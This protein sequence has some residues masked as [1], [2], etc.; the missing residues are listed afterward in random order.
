MTTDL[1]V[2]VG[3][4][5]YGTM[6]KA[7][8]YGYTA[9]PVIRSLPVLPR[10]QVISGRDKGAV[11]AACTRLGLNRW[12]ADWRE[13]VESDDVDI[14]D[15]CTPP[16][17]H[18]EII[19]AAAASGKAIICEKPLEVSFATWRMGCGSNLSAMRWSAPRRRAHGCV[20]RASVRE[21]ESSLAANEGARW[22]A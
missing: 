16:G 20:P 19:Q 14:V 1:D 5:G 4:V 22:S 10:A 8:D 11:A 18:A 6:G 17:T 3:V 21:V 12:T 9:V 2:G 15:I 13:L 7:R